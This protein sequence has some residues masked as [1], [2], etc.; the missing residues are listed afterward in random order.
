MTTQLSVIDAVRSDITKMQPQFKAALPQHVSPEK[1][2]R[3]LLTAVQQTPALLN[4]DRRSLFG[5]AMRAAQDGLLPDGREGA[6]VTF[7][8]Q[9]QWMPMVAGIMKKVRNS[10]E[11]STWSVQVV[12]AADSFDFQLGDDE[13]IEHKPA[14]KDRGETIGA[15]SIV[16]MKDGEKSRE[17]MNVDEIR[18]IQKRSRSGTSGPWVSDF[19]EMAKKTVVRR[20]A[21][22]LPMS[23]DLDEFIR[24]DDELFMPPEPAPAKDVTPASEQ[25]TPKGRNSKLQKVVDAEE[26][27]DIPPPSEVPA[28]PADDNEYPI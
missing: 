14:M 21:K 5:A 16:T 19:D 25:P 20:H 11:I 28:G 15:Y 1:F 9:A 22:R 8:D 6:I 10:G 26:P 18:A 17:W 23:T 4:A 12:K 27:E 3:V 7:K 24:Q 2:Q 13:R